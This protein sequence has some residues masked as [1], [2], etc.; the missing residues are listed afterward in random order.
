MATPADFDA[1]SGA[2]HPD[3]F[4]ILGPHV[5]AGAVVIRAYHPSA[6]RVEIVRDG[7]A[8]ETTRHAGGIFEAIFPDAGAI[9]DYRIHITYPDGHAM[10]IDDPYRYGRVITRMTSTFSRETPDHDRLARTRRIGDADGVHRRLGAERGSRQRRRRLQRVGRP[11]PSDA[12]SGRPGSGNLHPGHGQGTATSS[13]SVESHGE[14]L[15]KTD[16]FGFSF[17]SRR[18]PPES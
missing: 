1:L 18:S 17:E 7:R 13:R 12:R 15:L 6:R 11:G 4:S 16:P 2:R 5:E 9:F 3:P 14:L 10:V 8:V